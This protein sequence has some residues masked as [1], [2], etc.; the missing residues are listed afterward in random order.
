VARDDDVLVVAGHAALFLLGAALGLWGVFLVP[1]RLP[2]GLEGLSVVIAVVGNLAAAR[3]GG[4]G[5][6]TPLAAAMPGI[7][8]LVSVLVLVGGLPGLP[9]GGE[10]VLLPGKLPMDPG[11]VN[12]GLGWVFGGALGALAGVLWVAHV[13][14]PRATPSA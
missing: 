8:W 10:D 6:A 7:G 1:L 4:F 5:F 3:L 14:R 2:G 11:I 9:G 12:V 13:V